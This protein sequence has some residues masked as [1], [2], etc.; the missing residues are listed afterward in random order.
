MERLMADTSADPIAAE[1]PLF[2]LSAAVF[3]EREGKILIL[4]RAGGEA[5]GAW[6]IPGGAVDAGE[7]VEQAARRELMEEAGLAP[8]GPLRCVGVVHMHVY[9]HDSLQVVYACSCPTGEVRISH[10]HSGARWIDPLEYRDR[11]F[12]D[13]AIEVAAQQSARFGALLRNVRANID[14]YLAWRGLR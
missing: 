13:A 11:Y 5:T 14:E 8:D 2:A 3:V 7:T 12:T 10:E 6:Y 4:K 9:G 1:P